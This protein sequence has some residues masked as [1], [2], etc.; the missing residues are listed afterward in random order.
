M[1]LLVYAGLSYPTQAIRGSR[2]DPIFYSHFLI[3]MPIIWR[4]YNGSG[5]RVG[6]GVT[7]TDF[8][9]RWSVGRFVGHAFIGTFF[10]RKNS[11]ALDT[12]SKP[13]TWKWYR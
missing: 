2:R 9:C 11:A 3:S 13:G 8:V 5:H 6:H 1:G 7:L 12:V 4:R 10:V